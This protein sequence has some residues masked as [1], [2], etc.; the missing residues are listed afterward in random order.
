MRHLP[1]AVA[2][3]KD[4][5]KAYFAS[6]GGGS[7]PNGGCKGWVRLRRGVR[8]VQ[9]STGGSTHARGMLE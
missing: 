6:E 3:G 1:R 5:A 8:H 4:G 7:S 9:G 2:E